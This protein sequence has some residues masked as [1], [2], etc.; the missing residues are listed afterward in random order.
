MSDQEP[1]WTGTFTPAEYAA[2][3]A[4]VQDAMQQRAMDALIVTDPA[5]LYYLTGYN[6]WSFYMPQC[7]VVPLSGVPHLFARAMDAQ[8]AHHTA[9]LPPEQVHGYPE[10]LVHR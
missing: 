5:N 10:T 9:Y 3:L 6:A 1:T 2:R 7:L 4:G 8:G